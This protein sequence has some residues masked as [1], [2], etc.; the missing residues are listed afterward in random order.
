M[1]M[2]TYVKIIFV[3]NFKAIER[4]I[5]SEKSILLLKTDSLEESKLFSTKQ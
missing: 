3:L 4:A 2:R 5:W 1:E